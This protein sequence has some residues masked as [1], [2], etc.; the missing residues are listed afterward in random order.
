MGNEKGVWLP[1]GN[2]PASLPI[3]LS[4]NIMQKMLPQEVRKGMT[5]S[6]LILTSFPLGHWTLLW[7]L[8]GGRP[9]FIC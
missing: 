8:E 1:G 3:S 5:N 9:K 2:S 6:G 4:Y 7:C